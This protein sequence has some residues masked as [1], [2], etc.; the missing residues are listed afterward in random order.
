MIKQLKTILFFLVCVGASIQLSA[1]QE[2]QSGFTSKVFALKANSMGPKFVVGRLAALALVGA[3]I[4]C[5]IYALS[6]TDFEHDPF[7][8]IK[9]GGLASSISAFG[10]N[11][12]FFIRMLLLRQQS[13]NAVQVDKSSLLDGM[14]LGE[15]AAQQVDPSLDVL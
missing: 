7:K 1:M 8:N 9:L 6:Q 3:G 4:G 13:L 11:S 5:N 12:W 14:E 10:M 2:K 15:V